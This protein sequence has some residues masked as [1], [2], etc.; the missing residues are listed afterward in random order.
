MEHILLMSI[1]LMPLLAS[2]LVKR[3]TEKPIRIGFSLTESSAN[4][5]TTGTIPIVGV[6]ALGIVRGQTVGIGLEIMKVRSST[7]I[8][9]VEDDQENTRR[10]Q[11]VKGAAPAALIGINDQRNIFDRIVTNDNSFTTSGSASGLQENA[12]FDDLTDGDGNGELVFDNEIHVS[13]QGTGN[14]DA[15]TFAGYLLAHL[16]EFTAN[17]AVFEVLENLQG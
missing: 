8:P 10:G 14:D 5:F 1:I 6:P 15:G 7:D 12:I 2:V 9:T 16:V 3:L 4:T 13:V 11:I 17:E